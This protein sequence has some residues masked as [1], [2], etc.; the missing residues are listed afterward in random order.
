MPVCESLH[1]PYIF[2]IVPKHTLPHK[3]VLPLTLCC[4][5]N[6]KL[7]LYIKFRI[8]YFR[9]N[10]I[11]FFF[12]CKHYTK[13][14]YTFIEGNLEAGNTRAF[15]FCKNKLKCSQKFHFIFM[16]F[17]LICYM[18]LDFMTKLQK[19]LAENIRFYRK[20]KGMTQEN[21]AEKVGTATNYIGRFKTGN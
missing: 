15:S 11:L 7:N 2:Y 1:A 3:M 10:H 21:L 17:M 9:N 14:F 19:Q 18:R 5:R 13:D 16:W 4:L 6:L 8:I 20:K 12:F